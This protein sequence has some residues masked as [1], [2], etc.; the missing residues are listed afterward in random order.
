MAATAG[1]KAGSRVRYENTN[2]IEKMVSE[3]LSKKINSQHNLTILF[4][5]PAG[6]E[7]CK[8]L[9][10]RQGDILSV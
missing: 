4:A 6:I 7:R 8:R 3:N 1:Q 5:R 10:A 9:V 2:L